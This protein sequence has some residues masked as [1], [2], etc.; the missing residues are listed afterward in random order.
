[1]GRPPATLEECLEGLGILLYIARA[2][3]GGTFSCWHSDRAK[4][5]SG[6]SPGA[7]FHE[8]DAV[9]VCSTATGV[10]CNGIT[11]KKRILTE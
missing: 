2:K 6:F 3:P 1:M 11:K 5:A 4:Q 10:N 9:T 8:P 7:D